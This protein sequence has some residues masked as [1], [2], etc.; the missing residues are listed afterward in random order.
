MENAG[1]GSIFHGPKRTVHA[2]AM[3]PEKADVIFTE[4]VSKDGKH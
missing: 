3:D 2:E 1:Y 4:D